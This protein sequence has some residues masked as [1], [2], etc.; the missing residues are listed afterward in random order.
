[1]QLNY[2]LKGEKSGFSGSISEHKDELEEEILKLRESELKAKQ[3][4]Q[5]RTLCVHKQTK[6]LL[7]IKHQTQR[8]T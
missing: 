7:N 3:R 4:T 1:M 8:Q 6:S 2:I 5:S